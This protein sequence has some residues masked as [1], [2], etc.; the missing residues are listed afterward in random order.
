MEFERFLVVFDPTSDEQPA[1]DRARILAGQLDA[2]I[3]L[4]ACINEEQSTGGDR[5]A[6]L[7]AFEVRLEAAAQ[8]LRDDGL[9]VT[10]Q[11][12]WSNDW[13]KCSVKAAE[14]S[15]ADL[16]LKSSFSHS[17]SQ[18]VF[19]R[20]SDWTLIRECAAPV[21]LVKDG[22]ERDLDKVLVAVDG[23]REQVS[24]NEANARLLDISSRLIERDNV[25]VHVLSTSDKLSNMPDR[26]ALSRLTGV[27]GE[28]LHIRVG[29]A[30]DLII[31]LAE[32]LH[33]G[34]LIIGNSKRS[35]VTAALN[36]NTIERV[37]DRL[38]CDLVAIH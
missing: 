6:T 9:N 35:G 16:V 21:M 31:E 24:S 32:S 3:H 30:D 22:D 11:V 1:L 36:N 2:S 15:A 19:K 10:T 5:A 27:P 26:A 29:D 37:L 20:T 13:Y 12:T 23:R 17:R 7:A 34:T 33:V 4:Y 8:P 25:E 28:R 14:D 18:R 38:D